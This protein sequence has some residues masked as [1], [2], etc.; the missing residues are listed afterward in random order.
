MLSF[1]FVLNMNKFIYF[2]YVTIINQSV[3]PK[4]F[5][6]VFYQ[7]A[8]LCKLNNKKIY[9]QNLERI[10]EKVCLYFRWCTQRKTMRIVEIPSRVSSP[11]KLPAKIHRE[12]FI[13]II[14]LKLIPSK[15]T[16]EYSSEYRS[17]G[18]WLW[19]LKTCK[20]SNCFKPIMS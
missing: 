20:P 2:L 19:T 16:L 6:S 15:Y 17:R 7:K 18:Q 10:I 9:I 1:F 4:A 13:V 14:L 5:Y 12:C 11:N 3:M 8:S